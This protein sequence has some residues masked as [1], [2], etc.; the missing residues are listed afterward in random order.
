[1]YNN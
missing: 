1:M